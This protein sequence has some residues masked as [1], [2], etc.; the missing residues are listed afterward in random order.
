MIPATIRDLRITSSNEAPASSFEDAG[1][2]ITRVR[3]L[4]T[5]I[6]TTRAR[7]EYP[8]DS[9]PYAQLPTVYDVD[10]DDDIGLHPFLKS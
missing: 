7:Y 9:M 4:E 1:Q 2:L 6:G 5:D 3:A 10:A 8:Y